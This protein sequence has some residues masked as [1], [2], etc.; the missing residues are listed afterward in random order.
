M[1]KSGNRHTCLLAI[2]TTFAI[3]LS[4]SGPVLA[5]DDGPRAYW[6]GRAGT[7]VVSFQYIRWD[8]DATGSQ[9]FAPGQYIYANSNTEA[10]VFIASWASHLTVLNRPSTFAFSLA[11]GDV[12]VD[13]NTTTSPPQFLP[14]GVTPGSSF[15]QS[16]SGFGDPNVQFDMNL[17]GTPR[18][19]SNV[20]LLNY[21]PTWTIDAAALLA[22]PIGEYDDNKLVNLGLNRWWGRV[23]LPFKYHFGVFAPGY[24]SSFEVVPS[25]WLFAEND[26]FIGQ[27]L[28]NDPLWQ[29]EAHL[30]HDFTRSLFGSMDLLYRRG[31]LSEINGIEVGEELDVGNIGFTLNFKATDNLAIRTSYMSNVFGDDDLDNSMLRIQFVYAWNTASENA[32]KLMKGH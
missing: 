25:I 21:E 9:Q 14:P 26:D 18:L 4:F 32:K 20:D 30:T 12:D 7:E 27:K 17:F 1:I 3:I 24:M 19:K 8:I 31:F 16:S 23:A 11:G 6:K 22:F 5:I 13:V 2:L 15:S 29:V 28:E 10:S